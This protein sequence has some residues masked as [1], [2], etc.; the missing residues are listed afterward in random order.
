MA[1]G[2]Q[3]PEERIAGEEVVTGGRSHGISV[4]SGGNVFRDSIETAVH[5]LVVY[6]LLR[7][8]GMPLGHLM[9]WPPSGH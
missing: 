5:Q 7:K 3:L 2:W 9:A 4:L 6:E 8:Q 1:L